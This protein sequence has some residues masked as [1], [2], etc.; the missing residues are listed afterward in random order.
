MKPK[1]NFV[2]LAIFG[3]LAIIIFMMISKHINGICMELSGMC[4]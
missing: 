2:G 4:W 3:L 1:T